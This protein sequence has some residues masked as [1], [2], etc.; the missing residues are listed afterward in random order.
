MSGQLTLHR[1]PVGGDAGI[2]RDVDAGLVLLGWEQGH[3]DV[4]EVVLATYELEVALHL[5]VFD[6]GQNALLDLI[7]RHNGGGFSGLPGFP[8]AG[9]FPLQAVG[10]S[11]SRWA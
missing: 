5:L 3:N 1:P 9:F 7:L 8:S 6:E 11:A 4:V 10:R 2:H